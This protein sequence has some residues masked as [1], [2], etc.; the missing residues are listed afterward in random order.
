MRSSVLLCSGSA[1]A[2]GI[3][4]DVTT[5]L[6]IISIGRYRATFFTRPT[7]L[8]KTRNA[9]RPCMA[10]AHACPSACIFKS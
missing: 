3:R 2:G 5:I 4:A 9:T 8:L 10:K 7:Q 1:A 6:Q